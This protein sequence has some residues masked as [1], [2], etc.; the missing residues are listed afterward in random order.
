MKEW[1]QINTAHTWIQ[2]TAEELSEEGILILYKGYWQIS[3]TP[4]QRN[5][6]HYPGISL[7]R[8]RKELIFLILISKPVLL[9]VGRPNF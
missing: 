9:P 1:A 6:L 3:L 4:L 5:N 2:I 8:R 7:G